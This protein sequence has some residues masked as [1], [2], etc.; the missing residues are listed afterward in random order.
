[1]RK[2]SILLY[3]VYY[4]FVETMLSLFNQNETF[5]KLKIFWAKQ[6]RF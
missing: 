6:S 3:F 1:M 2:Y 4:I 5:N